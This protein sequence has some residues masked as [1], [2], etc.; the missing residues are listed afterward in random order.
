MKLLAL[1]T[2]LVPAVALGA[3]RNV[4]AEYPS[5]ASAVAGASAG[6]TIVIASGEYSAAADVTVTIDKALSIAAE[7]DTAGETDVTIRVGAGGWTTSADVSVSG[8]AFNNA[9]TNRVIRA[10]G[11]AL[12]ITDCAFNNNASGAIELNGVAATITDTQFFANESSGNGGAIRAVGGTLVA[13]RSNF[14]INRAPTAGVSGGAVFVSSGSARFEGCSFNDN[15]AARGVGGAVACAGETSAAACEFARCNVSNNSASSGGA[16]SARGSYGVSTRVTSSVLTS[17]HLRD[18]TGNGAVYHAALTGGAVATAAFINATFHR[19]E[20]YGSANQDTGAGSFAGT[21]T[22]KLVNVIQRSDVPRVF[23][24]REAP[25]AP[26]VEYSNVTGVSAGANGNIT[27]DPQFIIPTFMIS[28]TSPCRFAGTA[29]DAPA[30]DYTDAPW[31]GGVSIG[32]YAAQVMT[33]FALTAPETITV[34]EAFDVRIDAVDQRGDTVASYSGTVQLT[35][36]DGSAVLPGATALVAGSATASVTLGTLG[37]QT[38]TVRDSVTNTLAGTHTIQVVAVPAPDLAISIADSG[39][40]QAGATGTLTLTIRNSGNR[41]TSGDVSVS[42][43]LPAHLSLVSASGG[44][45]TCTGAVCARSS[46]LDY[47]AAYPPITVAVTIAS[48]APASVTT[49]ASVTSGG[50]AN[51]TNDTAEHVTAVTPVVAPPAPD[52]TDE[53]PRDEDDGCAATQGA[54]AALA[55]LTLL[56]RRRS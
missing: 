14:L 9:T 34:D 7:V 36:T 2:I 46:L 29:T 22:L 48:D 37:E 40:F 24:T 17:N 6:D 47:G 35:S 31:T 49:T 45:W 50:D 1:A 51:S 18:D 28:D 15:V 5:I 11:G 32:A 30:T 55:A 44:G 56:R 42:I 13:T 27:G 16:F 25:V 19:N 54:W 12:T 26:V 4:P 33:G 10:T 41:V 39:S 20:S 8:I 23:A 53:T 43:Q 52:D 38:I 21:G 3:T